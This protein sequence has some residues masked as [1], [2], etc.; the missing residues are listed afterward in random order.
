MRPII[1]LYAVADERSLH[2]VCEEEGS[3]VSDIVAG[4]FEDFVHENGRFLSPPILQHFLQRYH[5]R[6]RQKHIIEQHEAHIHL[7]HSFL[8]VSFRLV[9]H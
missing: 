6:Q 4:L 2:H 9:L 8:S 1:Q 3:H 7:K 5:P